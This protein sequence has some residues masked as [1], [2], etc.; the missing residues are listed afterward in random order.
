MG[1]L[2]CEGACNRAR[3]TADIEESGELTSSRGVVVDD[4]FIQ[5]WAVTAAIFGV[6]CALIFS[7]GREC[8]FG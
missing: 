4:N 1:E 6:V 3:T 8:S 2:R 5:V 7:E